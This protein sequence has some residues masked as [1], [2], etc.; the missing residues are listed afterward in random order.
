MSQVCMDLPVCGVQV[1]WLV[2]GAFI[3]DYMWKREMSDIDDEI[4]NIREV[5]TPKDLKTQLC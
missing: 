3:G 2:D 1:R 4:Q 5:R